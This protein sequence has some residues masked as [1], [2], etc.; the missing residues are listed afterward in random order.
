MTA[1]L[2]VLVTLAVGT[3]AIRATGMILRDKIVLP[4][5]LQSVLPVAATTLLAALVAT[6]V[7][8]DAGHLTLGIARPAGVLVGVVLAWRRAP[9]AVVVIAAAITAALLRLAG[10]P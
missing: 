1:A 3:Y 10:L 7:F 6:A 8:T 9:F 2:I 4:A 5:W